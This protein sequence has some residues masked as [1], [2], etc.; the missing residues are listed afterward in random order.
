[1]KL[2]V[3]GWTHFDDRK[4]PEKEIDSVA[5]QAIYDEIKENGYLFSGWHHNE[6]DKCAP[7]LNDG[8]IRRFSQRSWGSLMA[9]VLGEKGR[10]A[11]ARYSFNTHFDV[12][13]DRIKLP[14][15]EV[16][17]AEILPEKELYEE[18][19]ID[20]DDKLLIE[21]LSEG[22]IHLPDSPDKRYMHVKDTVLLINNGKKYRFRIRD[23]DIRKEISTRDL[24]AYKYMGL[25]YY[26]DKE[27]E[28]ITRKY[29]EAPT[30]VV[31]TVKKTR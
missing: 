18:H 20:A 29:E 17:E 4:Y 5:Y 31:L 22:T 25:S 21:A 7:V 12:D 26:S 23:I 24:I 2:K 8:C 13:E 27:M 15:K 28:K 1:M 10:Y 6:I 14:D 11:Y 19:V 16:N 3:I 30:V 9:D